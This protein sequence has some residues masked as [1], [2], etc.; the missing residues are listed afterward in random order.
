MVNVLK[1]RAYSGRHRS[2]A[3]IELMLVIPVGLSLVL[4]INVIW[5]S[6]QREVMFTRNAATL[7]EM[8]ARAGEYND[9]MES[10]IY[11]DNLAVLL[12]ADASNAYLY[13]EVQEPDDSL[14][15]IGTAPQEYTG[16]AIAPGWD[17]TGVLSRLPTGTTIRVDIWGY[18]DMMPFPV[19]DVHSW[20]LRQGHAAAYSFW[21][22]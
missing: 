12:G 11:T 18:Y 20:Q 2:Q 15:T 13:I 6:T 17:D 4:A 16:E 22:P 5:N 7:A 14:F 3:L 10:A 1:R 9:A 19:V 21:V 8:I